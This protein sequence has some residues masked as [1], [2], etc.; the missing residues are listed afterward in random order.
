M[1]ETELVT[2]ELAGQKQQYTV[3]LSLVAKKKSLQV[4]LAHNC[5]FDFDVDSYIVSVRI[6]KTCS[7]P[8]KFTDG[9]N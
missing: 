2:F 4:A 3:W 9:R 1:K 7:F 6:N 8:P 5:S